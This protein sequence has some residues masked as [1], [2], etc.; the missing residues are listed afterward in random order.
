MLIGPVQCFGEV[1]FDINTLLNDL[2]GI[3]LNVDW[4][5]VMFWVEV[6]LVEKVKCFADFDPILRYKGHLS[7]KL[8][9]PALSYLIL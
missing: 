9:R 2:G 4:F 3:R 8:R 1:N 5:S 6:N 7:D